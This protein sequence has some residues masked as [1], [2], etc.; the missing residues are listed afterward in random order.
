MIDLSKIKT[1]VENPNSVNFSEMS[2]EEAVRLM[3]DEDFN[4]VKCI[5]TQYTQIANLIYKT[6]EVLKNGG[7]IIYMGAGTSGR[8]G[9]LDAVE[10]PPTFGVDY[11]K[12]IGLIAGGQNAFVKAVEGAEDEPALGR[13][14]LKKLNCPKMT[15]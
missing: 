3:N 4:A 12:V 14:D 6:A 15:S 8:L 1:E 5:Q 2:I 7:R 11:D 9:L 10:C 13:E